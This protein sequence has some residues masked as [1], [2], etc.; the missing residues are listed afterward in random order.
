LTVG[1]KL[2]WYEHLDEYWIEK[3]E[4]NCIVWK[5]ILRDIRHF[6]YNCYVELISL[7]WKTFS[8][9]FWQFSF[10]SWV[11]LSKVKNSK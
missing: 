6:N 3:L 1:C 10:W 7:C 11:W 2:A 9:F 8:I 4:S 5:K